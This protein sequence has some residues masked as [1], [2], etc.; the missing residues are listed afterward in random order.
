MASQTPGRPANSTTPGGVAGSGG[1][2]PTPPPSS[3]MPAHRRDDGN[4]KSAVSIHDVASA[5]NVSI[6]TVSRVMNNPKLVSE[7]TAKRVNEVIKRLGY[8]PNALAQGL[9]SRETHVLGIALPDIHG[10]FYSE[11]MRGADAEARKHRYHL[12]ISSEGYNNSGPE[13]S[14][15]FGL[16]DGLAVMISEPRAAKLKEANVPVVVIDADLT[17]LGLDSIVVDNAIGTTEAVEHLCERTPA[18]RCYYA[19]GPKENYDARERA[20]AFEVALKKTGHTM[21]AEQ[22]Q[23][24]QYTPDWGRTWGNQLAKAGKLKGAAVLAGNDEIAMGIYDAAEDAGLRIPQDLRVVGFDDT[25]LASVVRPRLSSVKI[26]GTEL[27]A[28]AVELLLRRIQDRDASVEVRHIQTS[29][30]VRESSGN[31]R[32]RGR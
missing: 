19:G 7:S 24:G 28:A 17:S 8:V 25:R 27:G 11:L 18:N 30:V 26:P 6:A 4:L 13:N 21:T 22:V 3:A 10:E 16:I 9:S 20:E 2:A 15:A 14:L 12:L 32:E 5:A 29:L 23:F 1:A 31:D